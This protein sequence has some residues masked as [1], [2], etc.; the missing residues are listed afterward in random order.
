MLNRFTRTDPQYKNTGGWENMLRNHKGRNSSNLQTYWDSIRLVLLLSLFTQT[1]NSKKKNQRTDSLMLIQMWPLHKNT[2]RL[3]KE[4]G[5]FET[6][7][8]IIRG[9]KLSYFFILN[10]IYIWYKWKLNTCHCYRVN[11]AAERRIRQCH[12]Q[13]RNRLLAPLPEVCGRTYHQPPP[14]RPALCI[15]PHYIIIWCEPNASVMYVC[16]LAH[17]YVFA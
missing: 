10:N 16:L 5:D 11:W 13:S 14:I 12:A 1:S 7:P 2:V 9:F 3:P 17:T 8:I 15:D 6:S 4:R